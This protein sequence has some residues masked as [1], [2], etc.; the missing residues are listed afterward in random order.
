MAQHDLL[1]QG[2]GRQVPVN[3]SQVDEP[4]LL[5]TMLTGDSKGLH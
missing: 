3:V 1:D 2:R 4:M 5:E